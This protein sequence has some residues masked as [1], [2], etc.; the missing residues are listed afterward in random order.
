MNIIEHIVKAKNN[1][2]VTEDQLLADQVHPL[3]VGQSYLGKDTYVWYYAIGMAIRPK[4]ILEIGTRFG[5]SLKCM[6][7]GSGQENMDLWFFDSEYD[8]FGSINYVKNYFTRNAPLTRVT[9]T[10]VNTRHLKEIVLDTKVNLAHVDGDH[11]EKGAYEDCCLCLP[12]IKSGGYL[13]VDDVGGENGKTVRAGADRFCQE[14]GLKP[15][16]LDC[17]RGMYVIQIG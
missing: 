13:L 12:V 7:L 3:D 17:Y 14:N 2:L 6:A 10:K 9:A 1:C 15:E 16:Y 11:S 8:Y 5:Y 4:T